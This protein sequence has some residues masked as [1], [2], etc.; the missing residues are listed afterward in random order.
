MEG[1]SARTARYRLLQSWYR[2]TV[3]RIRPGTYRPRGQRE[4]QLGSLL[5][6]DDVT[7][8]PKSNFLDPRVEE[9]S[10]QR[11]A[12]VRDEGGTLEE[13][14]LRYNMLSSMPMCFNLFG[15]VRQSEA[16][17]EFVRQLL[18]PTAAAVELVECE[19][20][21]REP[22]STIDD[23][24]AFDAAI[25][26]KHEDGSRHLLGIETKYTESFSP[27][28]YGAADRDDAG[29]YSAIHE[30]CG[31]FDPTAEASLTGSTTNQLWRNCLLAAASERSGEF[32]S[33]EVVVVALADDPGANK[34]LRGVRTAM[35]NPERCR[36]LSLER[37]VASTSSISTLA[38][39]ARLFDQRYID[40]G[41]VA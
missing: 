38:D 20:T 9:Y 13:G 6:P 22:E 31:W 10:S 27:T 4:R 16:Q 7:G 35:T 32:D 24:T 28:R 30:S 39:W 40:L 25:V 41:P 33:A 34:A 21:P 18:D 5:L 26:T 14:R 36:L 19:W 3:L 1:D 29:K 37:I 2:E 8:H 17:L 15:M 12:L 23:R 11:A